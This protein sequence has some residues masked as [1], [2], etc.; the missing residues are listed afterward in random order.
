MTVDPANSGPF[1]ATPELA[2]SVAAGGTGVVLP[3]GEPP[4]QAASSAVRASEAT[5]SGTDFR[6]SNGMARRTRRR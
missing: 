1:W 4:P 2:G 6:R 3:L 5:G